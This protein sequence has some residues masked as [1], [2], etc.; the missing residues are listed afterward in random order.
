MKFE[1]VRWLFPIAVTLH[2]LEE[3]IWFPAWSKAASGWHQPV[4]V[5]EFWFAV[6]ILTALAYLVTGLSIRLGRNSW[7]TYLLVGYA[8]AM[9]LNVLIPHVLATVLLHQYMPGLATALLF[10]LP[11]MSSI[12]YLAIRDGFVT[13]KK[14]LF[15]SLGITVVLL[16]SL[17]ALFTAGR[18]FIG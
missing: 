8:F 3:A 6:T 18:I 5:S 13:W 16:A 11:I 4:E 9:L 7:A 2:N 12:L 17:P 14:S 10:N 1:T 15:V